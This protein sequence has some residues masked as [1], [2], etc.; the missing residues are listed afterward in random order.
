MRSGAQSGVEVCN[1]EH[2][3]A[4]VDASR[5]IGPYNGAAGSLQVL[6]KLPANRL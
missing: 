1:R 4:I 3:L 2:R 6:L 5:A